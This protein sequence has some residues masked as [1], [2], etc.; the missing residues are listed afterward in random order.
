LVSPKKNA[1][2]VREAALKRAERRG[3]KPGIP[4]PE[5]G[6]KQEAAEAA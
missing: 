2:A 5:G 6:G 3:E 4:P 1:K